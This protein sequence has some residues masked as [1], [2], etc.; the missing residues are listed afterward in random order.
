MAVHLHEEVV[1]TS[2][3]IEVNRI[4]ILVSDIRGKGGTVGGGA[5]SAK[6]TGKYSVVLEST[7]VD[8][9]LTVRI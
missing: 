8:P 4:R 6:K 7:V 9:P 5:L 2:Q 1:D 3:V